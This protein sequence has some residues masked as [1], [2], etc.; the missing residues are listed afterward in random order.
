M[1][2]LF[3]ACNTLLSFELAIFSF[4]LVPSALLSPVDFVYFSDPKFGHQPLLLRLPLLRCQM[5][6][7][8]AFGCLIQH[9]WSSA[10]DSCLVAGDSPWSWSGEA[11]VCN[12]DVNLCLFDTF[13]GDL[14][15]SCYISGAQDACLELQQAD[16][17]SRL[18]VF[19]LFV[20][21]RSFPATSLQ[22]HGLSSA[23]PN[24]AP[25][26]R[27]CYNLLCSQAGA[28][29]CPNSQCIEFHQAGSLLSTFTVHA[30]QS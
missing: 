28:R 27:C 29:D 11:L 21:R 5:R 8:S 15:H 26:A 20:G 12:S 7:R 3:S 19:P 25:A 1:L 16:F 23:A 22:L 24:H 30:V 4:G 14:I 6:P 10:L 9:V 13:S 18:V 17:S 2:H